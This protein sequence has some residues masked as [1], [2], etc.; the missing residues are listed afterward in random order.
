MILDLRYNRFDF[1][2][3]NM[4]QHLDPGIPGI[5]QH[6]FQTVC[7]YPAEIGIETAL[8]HGPELNR[9]CQVILQSGPSE[10]DEFVIPCLIPFLSLLQ[11]FRLDPRF[12]L[13]LIYPVAGPSRQQ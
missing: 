1:I 6:R 5:I 11:A 3:S 8:P 4:R 9:L 13:T 2:G 7:G 12:I 10:D